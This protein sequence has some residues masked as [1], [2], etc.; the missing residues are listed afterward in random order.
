MPPKILLKK[1]RMTLKTTFLV[2]ML[3][4]LNFIFAQAPNKIIAHRG[5]SSVAPENTLT[6]F[7]K[8][9]DIGA[10]YF[11]LDVHQSADGEIFVCHDASLKR[12]SSNEMTGNI[13]ELSSQELK[14]A[15]VGYPAKFEAEFSNE[16]VPTL[17]EALLLA[18]GKIKVCVEIKVHGAETEILK[19]INKTQMENE[20]IIFSFYD[21]VLL[22]IRK[23]NPTIPCLYLSAMGTKKTLK[24]A[25]E[26]KANAVG[27]GPLSKVNKAYLDKAHKLNLEVW[28]WTVNEE[29]DLK[30]LIDL[31]IDGII[32]NYPNIALRL[33]EETSDK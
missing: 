11:E 3:L 24:K 22:E 10:D 21:D 7:Q 23:Q 1:N 17:E 25:L 4:C 30:K 18:K 2:L 12:T 8:A 26:I 5:F 29:A 31:N 32:T 16:K 6:A 15:R 20:V 9:L 13:A 33:R 27:L 28:R 19:I 14:S